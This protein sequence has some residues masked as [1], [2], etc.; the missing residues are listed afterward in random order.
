MRNALEMCSDGERWV[1]YAQYLDVKKPRG[2]GSVTWLC[3]G[4]LSLLKRHINSFGPASAGICVMCRRKKV[5][6]KC[7]ICN[8]HCCFK[9]NP[10]QSSLSCSIDLHNDMYFGLSMIERVEL[11]GEQKNAFKRPLNLD[12]KKYATHIK[13]FEKQM[14]KDFEDADSD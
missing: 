12:V 1:S 4:D 3:S 14:R 7:N 2:S 5:Y 8:L 9:A 13:K 6:T 10:N 11:F